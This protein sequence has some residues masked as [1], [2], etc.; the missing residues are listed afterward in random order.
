MAAK[1]YG[2]RVRKC[3]YYR[4]GERKQ[5]KRKEKTRDKRE[6]RPREK[7]SP[8]RV[9][10][11]KLKREQSAFATRFIMRSR[12]GAYTRAIF[13][14]PALGRSYYAINFNSPA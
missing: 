4:H 9:T 7:V 2:G 14:K 1:T 8:L 5:E 10:R 12:E 11:R 3:E 13:R 6:K